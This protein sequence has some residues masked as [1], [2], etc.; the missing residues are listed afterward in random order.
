ML[1]A[2]QYYRCLRDNLSINFFTRTILVIKIGFIEHRL[3]EIVLT[4]L[5][6]QPLH[7]VQKS[8]KHPD[9]FDR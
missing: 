2:Y 4:L 8:R 1:F 6:F 9:T 3:Y 7:F 5:Q